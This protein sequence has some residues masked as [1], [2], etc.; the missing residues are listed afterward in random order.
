MASDGNIE[1]IACPDPQPRLED[2]SEPASLGGRERD[3]QLVLLVPADA[4]DA[5]SLPSSRR[6]C[7]SGHAMRSMLP[8]LATPRPSA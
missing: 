3:Q 2:G 5:G 7:G 1:R 4:L 8:S 6:G